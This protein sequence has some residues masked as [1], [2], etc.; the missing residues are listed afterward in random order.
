[1]PS[2]RKWG[3]VGAASIGRNMDMKGC[4]SLGANDT[5]V[6]SFIQPIWGDVRDHHRKA[7]R[8]TDLY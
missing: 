1:M 4:T 8:A 5:R 7:C 3:E 6:L 2:H